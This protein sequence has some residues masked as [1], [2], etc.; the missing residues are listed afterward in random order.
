MQFKNTVQDV[1]SE[2]LRADNIRI[3]QVNL[4][5]TCNMGCK[6]C[7]ISAGPER[8][9]V[10]SA[11]T[12]EAVLDVLRENNIKILDITGGAPELNPDFR[13]LIREAR[14]LGN[15]VIVRSNL[16]IFFENG[17]EDLPDFYRENR[18][19]VIASLPYYNELQVDKMRGS[20]TFQKSIKALQQLNSLGYGGES[21]ELKLDLV[22][23]PLGAFLPSSQST[24]GE[25]Y[26]KQLSK[27]FN[28]TFNHLYTFTNMPIG[29]FRDFLFRTNN[30]D[31]YMEKLKGAFNPKTLEKLMCKHLINVG[32]DGTLYDCDF[33]QVLGL[34]VHR[35]YPQKIS[36]F[37]YSVLSGRTTETDEHCFACT[38]GQGST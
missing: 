37:K 21:E 6:H 36:D 12:I 8:K 24:L 33:N 9:E 31:K 35:E 18:V 38:A 26:K 28:I 2:P 23:N 1:Q 13:N 29:R 16:T 17:K 22:Y 25:D 34:P 30:F 3:L 20:G 15:H 4:G 10:M 14:G 5:Y 27:N 11:D 19:E 7:H 32:W